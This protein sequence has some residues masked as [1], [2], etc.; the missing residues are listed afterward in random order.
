MNSAKEVKHTN[1]AKEINPKEFSQ[2]N[3]TQSKIET[4]FAALVRRR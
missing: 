1:S 2:K 4:V 3:Q